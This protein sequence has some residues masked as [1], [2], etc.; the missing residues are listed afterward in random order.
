[1]LE[2]I[3]SKTILIVFSLAVLIV[4]GMMVN[5]FYEEQETVEATKSF[6][7]IVDILN[8]TAALSGEISIKL[9]MGRY[10]DLESVLRIG[11]GSLFLQHKMHVISATL[12]NDFPI[13]VLG[14]DGI[15]VTVLEVVQGDILTIERY[16]DDDV[17]RTVIYIENVDATFSTAFTN[18]STS[19]MVL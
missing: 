13:K 6:Q 3:L 4:S 12:A 15:E 1:M 17:L 16:W 7:Q 8:Q 19:S 2:F 11:N 9:E 5:S 18:L 14:N 10:L